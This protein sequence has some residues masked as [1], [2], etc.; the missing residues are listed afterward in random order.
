M[1]ELTFRESF[2]TNVK[3]NINKLKAQAQAIMSTDE[4]T[5]MTP[6]EELEEDDN[7]E[8]EDEEELHSLPSLEDEVEDEKLLMSTLKST[9][10]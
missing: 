10:L 1:L 3:K 5:P 2:T 6:D 9:L 4:I 8:E 7:S